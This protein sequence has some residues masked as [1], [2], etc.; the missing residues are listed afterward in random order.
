MCAKPC[1]L[2]SYAVIMKT[3]LL[4]HV[5][6]V[7]NDSAEQLGF[8]VQELQQ[9][10]KPRHSQLSKQHQQLAGL[11]RHQQLLPIMGSLV[12]TTV[13]TIPHTHLHSS[14]LL[15]IQHIQAISKHI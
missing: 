13:A 10:S 1:L 14:T 4:V 6:F 9:L 8:F 7:I 2:L 11:Y 3:L 15:P 12:T 5:I